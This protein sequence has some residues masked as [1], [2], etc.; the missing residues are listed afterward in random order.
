MSI[1][2]LCSLWGCGAQ[3]ALQST[4]TVREETI[5]AQEGQTQSDEGKDKTTQDSETVNGENVTNQADENA[6]ASNPDSEDEITEG[7][8]D[9][10]SNDASDAAGN[11]WDSTSQSTLPE[12]AHVN[13]YLIT[14]CNT[15]LHTEPV[16]DSPVA[17]VILKGNFLK[18]T[19]YDSVWSQVEYEGTTYYIKSRYL[20][21]LYEDEVVPDSVLYGEEN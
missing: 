8:G 19:G 14:T 2:I 6:A 18:R 3:N 4:E 13:E 5:S 12:F 17:L 11:S 7:Y 15:N 10:S 16:S 21:N 1:G 20:R 9:D